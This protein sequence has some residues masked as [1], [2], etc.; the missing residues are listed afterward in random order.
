MLVV[1]NRLVSTYLVHSGYCKTAEAFNGYTNQP[2]DEDLASIK[3]RQSAY[4]L[5][6]L[7]IDVSCRDYSK[8]TN[9]RRIFLIRLCPFM[10]DRLL[11][12]NFINWL[13][14]HFT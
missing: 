1:F 13:Y 7:I 9:C 6:S 14:R 10:Q 2:F 5:N 8:P 12:S 3:T 4:K 11:L